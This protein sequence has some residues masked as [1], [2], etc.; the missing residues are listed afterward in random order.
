MTTFFRQRGHSQPAVKW[1]PATN[2]T[3]YEFV[4]GVFTT[5]DPELIKEMKAMGFVDEPMDAQTQVAMEVTAD[6]T[7]KPPPA[8]PDHRSVPAHDPMA[9]KSQPIAPGILEPKTVKPAP[10]QPVTVAKPVTQKATEKK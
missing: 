8:P 4:G 2:S 1:N 10:A 5:E 9:G 7:K 3:V 6:L